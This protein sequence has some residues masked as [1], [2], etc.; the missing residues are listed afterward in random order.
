MTSTKFDVCSQALTLLR[1][2]T[3][4]SFGD[5]SD[6]S[7]VCSIL[8]T[9]FLKDIF[10]RYPW[11]FAKRTVRLA[12]YNAV[13]E[14]GGYKFAYAVPLDYERIWAVY[15]NGSIID[16][17]TITGDIVNDATIPVILSN[18]ENISIEYVRPVDES[19]WPGYFWMY[20]IHALA[21]LLAGPVTDDDATIDKM[22]RLAYGAPSE[23]EK[24][25]K[26]GIATFVDSQ[27]KPSQTMDCDILIGARFS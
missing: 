2:K 12:K 4:A 5:G 15:S 17:Y 8:Y 1:A 26:Y 3:I 27:Q 21:D 18:H 22:H 7:D 13:P 14:N 6:E 20:A 25:G 19:K 10:S 16:D 11:S 23:N 9:P 24:G